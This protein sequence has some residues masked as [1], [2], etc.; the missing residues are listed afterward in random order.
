MTPAHKI[1]VLHRAFLH[2]KRN[3]ERFSNH[4][5]AE[6]MSALGWAVH[7]LREKALS[8]TGKEE[9]DV[10]MAQT[11]FDD[12]KIPPKPEPPPNRIVRDEVQ[13]CGQEAIDEETK[14]PVRNHYCDRPFEHE[15]PHRFE[16]R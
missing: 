9:L 7:E 5:D 3:P 16:E 13:L 15:G 6:L 2:M 12:E 8:K 14:R 4:R 1:V 10:L 11:R